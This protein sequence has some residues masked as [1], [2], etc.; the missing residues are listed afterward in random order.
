LQS[1]LAMSQQ[2]FFRYLVYYETTFIF[3]LIATFAMYL[4]CLEMG[5]SFPVAVAA[6]VVMILLL[7]YIM[8]MYG[9][10]YDYPELAFLAL[11]VFITARY[12]WM[13]AIPIAILGA[14]NTE[15]FLFIVLTLYPFIRRK[16]S[17][18][19]SIAG[20]AVLSLICTAIYMYLRHQFA[21]NPGAT[22]YLQYREQLHFIAHPRLW[23][24][25]TQPAYG[26]RVPQL[27]SFFPGSLLI[28]AV[29]RAWKG[30]PV[31]VRQHAKIAAVINVPLFLLFCGPAE[32][33]DLSMLY[34]ALLMVIAANLESLFRQGDGV[35]HD[36]AGRELA[37]AGS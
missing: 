21:Q 14:W 32:A 36:A 23:L 1:P 19:A 6:P 17:R 29:W 8:G 15:S 26:L 31:A 35:P 18:M 34:I 28:W 9:D 12:N 11:A 2:Y 5:T 25:T 27:M 16:N 30:I 33:R 13:W 37:K 4:V 3:A 20:V 10:I 7:P 22:A 24:F